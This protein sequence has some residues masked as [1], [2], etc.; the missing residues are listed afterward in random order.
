MP[1]GP[2]RSR[3]PDSMMQYTY[4]PRLAPAAVSVT[5][6]ERPP[7][8]TRSAA[9][10]SGVR[11]AF[12]VA[13]AATGGPFG[14]ADFAV[15]R[16]SLADVLPVFFTPAFAAFGGGTDSRARAF[17]R[18]LVDALDILAAPAARLARCGA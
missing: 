9:R 16:A 5:T 8:T 14:R 13:F 2:N 12:G 3:S 10:R 18:A 4:L 11:P 1:I 7:C 15:S 17:F 6:L